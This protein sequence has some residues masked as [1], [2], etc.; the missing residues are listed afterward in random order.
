MF[1]SLLYYYVLRVVLSRVSDSHSLRL[2]SI[3]SASRAAKL[4]GCREHTE[5]TDSRLKIDTLDPGA[6]AHRLTPTPN[7]ARAQRHALSELPLR[8]A[9]PG[10]C[11]QHCAAR[12]SREAEGA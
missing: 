2:G 7:M 9:L 11:P 3:A 12:P 5:R 4:S 10:A 6:N 8:Q 1:F